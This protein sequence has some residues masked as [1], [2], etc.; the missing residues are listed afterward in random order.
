MFHA[1]VGFYEKSKIWQNIIYVFG[2]NINTVQMSSQ[3]LSKNVTSSHATLCRLSFCSYEDHSGSN[4]WRGSKSRAVWPILW[5]MPLFWIW[6]HG[7]AHWQCTGHCNLLSMLP[8]SYTIRGM[9][10]KKMHPVF[11]QQHDK[12]D[13]FS[14]NSNTMHGC[15]QDL[16]S[17]FKTKAKIPCDR[18]CYKFVSEVVWFLKFLDNF[19]NL[20]I[21]ITCGLKHC[22]WQC[23]WTPQVRLRVL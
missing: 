17:V 14:S 18:C 7:G 12:F 5:L 22:H 23:H 15:V 4:A 1:V 20:P 21:F 9:D 11:T 19:L 13:T 8:G 10:K 6:P 16:V 3:W 2:I